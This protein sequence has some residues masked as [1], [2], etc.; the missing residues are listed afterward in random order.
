M[1]DMEAV[2]M[3][4]ERTEDDLASLRAVEAQIA[5]RKYLEEKR[6]TVIKRLSFLFR[7]NDY[8]FR[9]YR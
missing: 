4:K 2:E 8:L 7:F 3:A 5:S 6:T 9:K 1:V